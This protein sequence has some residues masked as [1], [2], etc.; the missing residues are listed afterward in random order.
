ME[1]KQNRKIK[2]KVCT[3]EV[4]KLFKTTRT[5]TRTCNTTIVIRCN[6]P[7]NLLF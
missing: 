5:R 1:K 2:D 3:C 7:S 6:Y 4:Y